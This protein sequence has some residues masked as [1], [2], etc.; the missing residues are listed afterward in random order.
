MDIDLLAAIVIAVIVVVA[1]LL[2]IHHWG[3]G[4][5]REWVRCPERKVEAQILVERRE[6]SFATLT[7]PDIVACSLLPEGKVD[8]GKKCLQF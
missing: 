4:R 2:A 7:P 1:G 5:Y 3:P 8:C 6:G